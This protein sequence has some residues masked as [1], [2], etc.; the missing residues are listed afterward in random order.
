MDSQENP[1]RI[2]QDFNSENLLS[3]FSKS[4]QEI[5]S[6]L[7]QEITSGIPQKTPS[8]NPQGVLSGLL[9]EYTQ[10]RLL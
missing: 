4:P 6:D 7:T 3:L 10:R 8:E 1:S 2:I 9:K 5:F